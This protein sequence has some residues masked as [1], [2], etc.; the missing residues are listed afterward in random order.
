MRNNVILER[1]LWLTIIISGAYL[2]I[3]APSIHK[4]VKHTP[5]TVISKPVSIISHT[6]KTRVDILRANDGS[7]YAHIDINGF[8]TT[9][10]IDTGATTT[11]IPAW[12]KG[13]IGIT[14]CKPISG[15]TANGDVTGCESKIN[16]IDINNTIT[17]KNI[18][19]VFLKDVKVVLLGQDV[20]RQLKLNVDGEL[21][22]I[23]H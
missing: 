9:A 16:R 19:A 11:A 18:N 13:N 10:V 17:V 4:P 7:F 23:G 14:K 6:K 22:K 15:H 1:L 2:F 5:M 20:L 3:Y 8:P 12:M 21:M